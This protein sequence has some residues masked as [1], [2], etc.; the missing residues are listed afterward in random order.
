IDIFFSGLG[1]TRKNV[2]SFADQYK[3]DHDLNL[4][5]AKAVKEAGIGTYI[6]ISSVGANKSSTF[7]YLKMKGELDQDVIDL[8]FDRTIT[9]RPGTLIG[10]REKGDG[11][12]QEAFLSIAATAHGTF[13]SKLFLS[14]IYD[15]EIAKIVAHLVEKEPKLATGSSKVTILDPNDLS[16]ILASIKK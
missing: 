2:N 3:I 11:L 9:V 10:K 12:W 7:P 4:E 16:Q 1:T 15:E 6:L 8:K 14:P 13:L 5:L